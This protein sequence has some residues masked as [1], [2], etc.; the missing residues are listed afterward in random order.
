MQ[1]SLLFDKESSTKLC[2]ACPPKAGALHYAK[3]LRY[4]NGKMMRINNDNPLDQYFTK[5]HIAK[6]LYL[7]AIEIISKYEKNNLN[8]FIWIDPC[9]GNGVFY[10]LLP[11]DRRIGID[12]NP[13]NSE[14]I[15]ADYLEYKIPHKSII[16]GNPP[17]GHRGVT[18]LEFINHSKNAH[19]VCFILPMF[20]ESNGKGSIKYRVKGLNL[21]HSERLPKNSFYIPSNLKDIDVKCVFQ[22]W[23]KH[24][25]P[26][27]KQDKFNWYSNKKNEPFKD[28]LRVYT[29]SLAK[30]R[31]CGKHWIFNEKADFYLSS[32][33]HGNTQIVHSF[34]EVNYKS[35]IAVVFT[36]KDESLKNK[37]LEIFKNTDWRKYGSLATNSCYHLG[38]SNIYQV[39]YDNLK[40]LK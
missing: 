10:N 26:K 40:Y 15:K 24:H 1:L 16:I 17:F 21:I 28:L 12:I 39:I 23:S 14:I 11:P 2:E 18:A 5:D 13:M 36:T 19:Y 33:F 32:T 7:R 3:A 6:K 8:D 38:K 35:G 4:V 9:A 22:I 27:N 37:M 20:F 30:N 34:E 25:L 31:E 29:V